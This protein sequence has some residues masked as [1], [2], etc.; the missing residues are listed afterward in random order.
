VRHLSRKPSLLIVERNGDPAAALALA[1]KSS[2]GSPAI[3]ALS[4][5]LRNR[6]KTSASLDCEI[7]PNAF[8]MTISVLI[9]TP[10]RAR[11]A[12]STLALAL[13][14]P[15]DQHVDARL[16]N[17]LLSTLLPSSN[18]NAGERSLADCSGEILPRVSGID[19][20]DLKRLRDSVEQARLEM[21]SQNNARFAIVGSHPIAS[22]VEKV[23]R[24]MSSWPNV[25][26]SRL[27]KAAH[28]AVSTQSYST[29]VGSLR[30]LSF[31][32][33]VRSGMTASSAA[34]SLRQRGSP[35]LAQI[36][37]LDD[38]WKVEDISSVARDV[39][40]CLRIDLSYA[41]ENGAI[42]VD[43]LRN[44]IRV[45]TNESRRELDESS[46]HG[47][48]TSSLLE[49]N[50]Q[51]AARSLAWYALS[52]EDASPHSSLQI[53]LRTLSSDPP[54]ATLELA[55][56]R[57]ATDRTESPLEAA[58]RQESGQT[59]LWATLASPC[60]AGLE[61][62][63]DA[64]STAA[65]IQ[66]VTHRFNSH[67]G[68]QLEP[69]ITEDGVGLIAHTS[70][71]FAA[72]SA[73][74]L[75]KRL[76][77]A[78]GIVAATGTFTG[79]ELAS[80]REEMLLKIGASP[81]RAWWQ[82]M[83]TLTANHPAIFEPLGTFDSLRSLDLGAVRARR[84]SWLKGPLRIA[85]LLNRN[86]EQ[87]TDLQASL[88]RWLDPH[89]QAVHECQTDVSPRLSQEIQILSKNDDD[90][91]S[92]AYVAIQLAPRIE[93]A[94]VYEHWLH[95]L[96]VRPGG[97]LDATL[98]RSGNIN[99]FTAD[100]RGPRY[101]RAVIIGLNSDDE[102]RLSEAVIRI[103]ELL[104]RLAKQGPEARELDMAQAW[105]EGQIRR[106]ELDP[107]RRLVDLWRGDSAPP[108]TPKSGFAT[109]LN[110]AL[111]AAPV[112]IIRVRRQP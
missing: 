21:R 49:S 7:F 82:L 33:R 51:R 91:D 66:G 22:E 69:Y 52:T 54:S 39:G 20:L 87:A 105:S 88:H 14:Q 101:N 37:A 58:F 3:W 47:D 9:D 16:L 46:A 41:N 98:V 86:R 96:L 103:R 18:I 56:R 35:F 34:S 71:R 60:G 32:W 75:A 77:D 112:T 84:S 10:E 73:T 53:H 79:A 102:S 31:A 42:F 4:Q 48:D 68:V 11:T 92:N 108:K 74:A 24:E 99:S 81:R 63:A 64:G 100:I 67:L 30:R 28:R 90:R 65:W 29:S 62:G 13:S 36:A 38:D 70:P 110:R 44:L 76:G 57:G 2:A 23:L 5:I 6:L 106:A 55:M 80:T 89:R 97:W 19:L 93:H 12:L 50:P 17:Q 43:R 27:D 8:G 61:T 83:D 40:G 104:N 72:E 1:A 25:E 15:V 94:V 109:Y 85:A 78:L 45:V 111:A 26:P 107:R 95:W 59:E